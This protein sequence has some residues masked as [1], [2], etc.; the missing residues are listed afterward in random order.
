MDICRTGIIL[1]TK[2]YEQ[3]VLFYQTLFDLELLFQET[4]GDFKL[5]CFDFLGSYLMIETGGVAQPNEKSIEQSATKFRFNVSNIDDA[6]AKIKSLGISVQINRN[7]WGTTINIC[8]PDGN[9]VGTR[10]EAT[11]IEQLTL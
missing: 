1:N 4:D 7:S 3:C 9:R 10:D 6:L 11:F 8:D 2:N 5:S